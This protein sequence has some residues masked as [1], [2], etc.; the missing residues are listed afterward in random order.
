MKKSALIGI[1]AVVGLAASAS[2]QFAS[3]TFTDGVGTLNVYSDQAG[4]SVDV[5]GTLTVTWL[6]EVADWTGTAP[7]SGQE[8]G[9]G[10]FKSAVV[11]GVQQPL[12]TSAGTF[13]TFEINDAFTDSNFDGNLVGSNSGWIDVAR[14]IV[15]GSA[16]TPPTALGTDGN[17]VA[18]FTVEIGGFSAADLGPQTLSI[19]ATARAVYEWQW[20]GAFWIGAGNVDTP[21]FNVSM[22]FTVVPTPGA[23]ALLGLG[24]LAA[25][26]RRR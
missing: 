22:P 3:G 17:P 10:N 25:V 15:F 14:G 2:A 26:R 6:V 5:G 20:A 9:V 11:G 8:V 18:A 16:G 13:E 23:L 4:A 24:G 21:V 12:M 19:D 7:P 1:A